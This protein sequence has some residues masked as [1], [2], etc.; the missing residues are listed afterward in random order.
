MQLLIACAISENRRN[1]L[2]VPRFMSPL[3]FRY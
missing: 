3:Q 2:S 1:N